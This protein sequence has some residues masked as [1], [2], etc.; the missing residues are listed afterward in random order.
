MTEIGIGAWL[1][2]SNAVKEL[3]GGRALVE[4]D[5]EGALNRMANKAGEIARSLTLVELS[6]R[7]DSSELPILLNQLETAKR[8]DSVV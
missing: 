1:V 2:I 4:Q 6:S 5:I 8:G 3:A 7:M